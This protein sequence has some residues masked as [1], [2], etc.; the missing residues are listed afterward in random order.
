MSNFINLANR[1]YNIL[2]RNSIAQSTLWI[3]HFDLP[4]IMGETSNNGNNEYANANQ[5]TDIKHR[6]PVLNR[7]WNGIGPD[8]VFDENSIKNGILF[9]SRVTI[10][11]DSYGASRDGDFSTGFQK[12]IYGTGRENFQDLTIEFYEM[13]NSLTDLILRP[14]NILVAHNSL[15]ISSVKTTI[16]VLPLRK[17]GKKWG[18]V[19]R[20]QFI[21]Y[22]AWPK[23]I[24]QEQYSHDPDRIITRP[25]YFAYDYY[26]INAWENNDLGDIT[27]QELREE[28]I[29]EHGQRLKQRTS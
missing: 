15:K 16:H 2:H 25:V 14:W 11:P 10:P 4:K 21:F 8:G 27:Y 12:G 24:S 22:N 19:G 5:V 26:T 7:G 29:F 18:N 13:N 3:I 20:K 6:E 23:S 9:A 1:F 28:Q 17:I